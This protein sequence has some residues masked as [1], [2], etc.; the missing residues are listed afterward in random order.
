MKLPSPRQRQYIYRVGIA[1]IA[2][3]VGYG[4]LSQEYALLWAALL[5][6]VL[7]MADNK[8]PEAPDAARH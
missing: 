6:P 4:V 5:A 3:L 8:V 1:G 7:G 2:V